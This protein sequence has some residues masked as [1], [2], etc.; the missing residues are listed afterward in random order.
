M[1]CLALWLALVGGGAYL[2][3]AERELLKGELAGAFSVS[4]VLGGAVYLLLGCLRGFTLI[5][6]TYLVLAAMAFLPPVTLFALTL[7]GILISSASIYYFSE[8]LELD[9][10]FRRKHA[11]GV[12]RV[13]G[14][15]QRH[16]LPIII[17]WSFFPLAPTDLICYVCGVL[18]VDFWKFIFGVLV[19]EGAICALYIFLGDQALHWAGWR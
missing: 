16:Q 5:P 2:F 7:L 8:W 18:R 10:Y 12:A 11:A 15:L 9:A 14:V 1:V 6:A 17:A 13:T 3:F 4:V 19:G